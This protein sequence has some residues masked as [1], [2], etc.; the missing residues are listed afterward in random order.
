[1]SNVTRRQLLKTAQTA[2]LF[3]P[4]VLLPGNAKAQLPPLPNISANDAVLLRPHEPMF[5]QYET[6]FNARTQLT[7][8]LRA[9]CETPNGLS[10][11]VNW[12]RSNE[13]PFAIR[14]G[15]HSYEGFS[16]SASVVIDTRLMNAITVDPTTNTATVGA[17]ASL[18]QLY[19]AIALHGFAFPGGSCPTVGVSG[20]ML[21]GGYGYLARPFGL[22]CDGLL[23]IALVDP[24]GHQ[25]TAD[26][27]QNTD[28]YWASRGG[29]GGSFGVATSYRV[30]LKS[31][32]SVLIFL[33]NARQL[34]LSSATA[35]MKAWQ[36]W[37]PQ[38]PH[39]IDSNLVVAGNAA[40]GI[41]LHYAGQSTGTMA[42]LQH[43]LSQLPIPAAVR[44]KS[45]IDAVNFFSGG[46][47]YPVRTMKGKSYYVTS[48][49][50]DAG[51]AALLSAIAQRKGNIYA[52][53]DAYGGAISATAADATA[54]AHRA[55]TL[56][57]IQY[58]S[59]WTDPS[60][61]TQRLTDM[62]QFYRAL[63]PYMS[64]GAYVNYPDLDLAA[65]YPVAYWAGNL[66]RLKQIKANFDPDNVF[67]HAQSVPSI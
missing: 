65:N 18:G 60:Q 21:G 15:G 22:A 48:P 4:A 53:C 42:E 3:A 55:G 2:A 12:C 5:G 44:Q 61:T 47:A 25:V 41:S 56:Y 46:W 7:P 26:A 34:S 27:Q 52:I 50:T 66:S 57:C 10:T 6:S 64:G 67:H 43:E 1:M 37:A 11:M 17:G 62:S 54:F 59:E 36:A 19:Q 13:L 14:C 45:F 32:R 31:V 33:S 28:L 49:L 63:R 35:F 51:I 58:G 16:Q 23:S 39:T 9:M 29:G 30:Q 24:Q 20:H 40:G 8:R 38:A